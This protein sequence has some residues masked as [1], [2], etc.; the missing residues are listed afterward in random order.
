VFLVDRDERCLERRFVQ[1]AFGI[2]GGLARHRWAKLRAAAKRGNRRAKAATVSGEGRYHRWVRPRSAFTALLLSAAGIAALACLPRA[3]PARA[4]SGPTTPVGPTVALFATNPSATYSSLYLVRAG[5]GAKG[6]PVATFPHREGAVVRGAVIPGTAS[7]LATADTL[8]TRDASFNASL[9]R[10]D[11]HAGST[12][13]CDRVVHGSRPLVTPAGRVFV[14]RGVAGPDLGSAMRVDD[15]TIDEIDAATGTTRTIHAYAGYLTFI[16]GEIGGKLL[17]YRVGPDGAD[18]I[19]VDPDTSV[20]HVVLP[21][22]LPFARDFSVAPAQG[23]AVFQER[24][25]QNSR[26]WVVDRVDL[27]SGA[28]TRLATGSNPT[29]SPY[30]LADGRVLYNPDAQG[31]TILGTAGTLAPLGPGVDVVQAEQ[32]GF[33]AALHTAPGQL[34]SAFAL[35]V[36]S[37]VAT[38]IATPSGARIVIAGFMPGGSAP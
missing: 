31:L 1:G 15:L 3:A 29:L 28:R 9:F 22:L 24:D 2:G 17:I 35:D 38:R 32:G 36:T 18:L 19:R 23:S 21:A 10:I 12:L 25:E 37:G 4:Q 20:V 13:L 11:P 5:D 6:T 16:A 14:A 33:I 7:V 27:K 30:V 34:P 26:L 8:E